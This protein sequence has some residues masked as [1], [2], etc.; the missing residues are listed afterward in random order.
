MNQPLFFRF[1]AVFFVQI[2][3]SFSVFSQTDTVSPKVY[4][5]PEV[6]AEFP[7]GTDALIQ[8]ISQEL[9]YPDQAQKDKAEGQVLVKFIVSPQ[10]KVM[11]VS[12]MKRVH[13]QLD[14][15]AIAVVRNLPHFEP[16]EQDGKPVFIQYVLPINF[17]LGE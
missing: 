4:E 9:T 5:K 16:G 7:G 2:C 17:S 15:A 8:H 10:G 6:M 12:V 1:L 14:S 11:D 13:P 3:I